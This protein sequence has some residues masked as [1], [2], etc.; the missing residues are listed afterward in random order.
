MNSSDMPSVLQKRPA[1]PVSTATAPMRS[2]DI[3][4]ESASLLLDIVRFSAAVAVVIAHATH[5]EFH[6][7][8]QNRQY[9]G[10][11]AVPVFFVL[12][13][14]VIRFVTRTR[15]SRAI[16]YFIDRASRIYSV[17]VPAL[18]VT[19]LAAAICFLLD[20][21]RFVNDWAATFDHPFS[22]LSFNLLFVSQAWGHNTIPFIDSPFWSLGYECPYY[23][24]YGLIF[25]LRG[26]TRV[27]ACLLFAAI[28]GPQV[29]FLLPIWWL[30]CWLYDVYQWARRTPL[31]TL[32]PGIA[33]AWLLFALGLSAFGRTQL[34]KLPLALGD[35]ITHLPNPLTMLGFD[36]HR[37]TMFAV[38]VGICSSL[39][40]FVL[41]LALDRI[42]LSR[43]ATWARAVRRIA[44]GT[45]A[46]YL[47]HYPLLV[48]ALFLGLLSVDH[49]M[50]NIL[51]VTIIC[52]LLILF[53]SPI[54]GLK[55]AM[56]SSLN[57]WFKNPQPM[58]SPV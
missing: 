10:D 38:A 29:V 23:I 19:L 55:R 24:F 26:W 58:R 40:L 39:I 15:E 46:I 56:R 4:P 36:P 43:T 35:R 1:S 48:L 37:A 20:R 3:L 21:H 52:V 25:F 32:V 9:L 13:G 18:A 51:T 11:I 30:G 5:D 49:P 17:V 53:A 28:L 42:S 2:P 7:Y 31:V 54:D 50:T 45:F 33:S 34:L 22:R 44:D 6:A 16:E 12:S 8:L 47:M 27:A 57:R 14:F 41:L